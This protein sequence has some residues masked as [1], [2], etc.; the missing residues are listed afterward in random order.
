MFFGT[1]HA[2]P[3]ED[4]K[5][6]FGRACAAILQELPGNSANDIM[7]ALKSGSL[8]SDV[9]YEGWKHQVHRYRIVTFYEGV[10][11]VRLRF[12]LVC[13]FSTTNS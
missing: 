10:G 6:K 9:L 4:S 2:G 8:L 13:H 3:N 7:D 5:V 11:D 1:P 12:S